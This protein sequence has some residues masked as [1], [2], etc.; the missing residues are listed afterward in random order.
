MILECLENLEK[1]IKLDNSCKEIAKKEQDTLFKNVN[2]SKKFQ[3]LI[4]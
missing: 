2:N 3:V 1:S 4:K